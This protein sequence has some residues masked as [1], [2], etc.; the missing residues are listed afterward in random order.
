VA[1]VCWVTVLLGFC[2]AVVGHKQ[3][4]HVHTPCKAW[5]CVCEASAWHT[6]FTPPASLPA[7]PR[8]TKAARQ[9]ALCG[10]A[11]GGLQR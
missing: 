5:L 7:D 6:H 9:R 2:G 8:L 3:Q 1:D 10:V 4:R 11:D